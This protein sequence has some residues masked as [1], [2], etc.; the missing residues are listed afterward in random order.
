LR[1]TFEK[2]RFIKILSLL[3]DVMTVQALEFDQFIKRTMTLHVDI[4]ISA[5]HGAK[6]G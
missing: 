5:E 6:T 2:K 1:I 4:Q 3:L